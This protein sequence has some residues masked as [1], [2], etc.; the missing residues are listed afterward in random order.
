MFFHPCYFVLVGYISTPQERLYIFLHPD[1]VFKHI[2]YAPNNHSTMFS[3]PRQSGCV[4]VTPLYGQGRPITISTC[5]G[6]FK[7]YTRSRLVNGSELYVR[8][9]SQGCCINNKEY[10]NKRYCEIDEYKSGFQMNFTFHNFSYL[11]QKL[12]DDRWNCSVDYFEDFKGHFLCDLYRDCNE[13]QDEMTCPY[14]SPECPPGS[15]LAGDICVF[16][17]EPIENL[18]HFDAQAA[19]NLQGGKL[20]SLKTPARLKA[21]HLVDKYFPKRASKMYVGIYLGSSGLPIR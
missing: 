20:A 1:D 13:G 7:E 3:F 5:C 14:Y 19:C 4:H 6:P 21:Y 11:P 2:I 12:S 15:F 16:V 9:Y 18:Q 10:T 17:S 8:F